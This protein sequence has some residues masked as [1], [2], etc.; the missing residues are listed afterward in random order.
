MKTI[1]EV[2]KLSTGYLAERSVERA[3]RLAE[4][5]LASCMGL[6]RLELYMQFDRPV[7]ESELERL[8]P[9][10]K[11]L[12]SH[13]P[14]EYVL[15]T[16]EFAGCTLTVNPNVL[17]PRPETEILVSLLIKRLEGVSLAGKALWDVCCGSGCIGLAL[18][19][20][21]PELRVTLS[22]VSTDALQLA[23][24]N[25]KANGLEV[26]LLQGDFLEPLEGRIVDILVCNPPYLSTSEYLNCPVSVRDFEPK[27]ALVGGEQ[28]TEFYER[29]AVERPPNV[30]LALEIGA[31]QGEA[32]QRIFEGQGKVVQDWSGK[33]RFF[34]LEPQS[35]SPV[36]CPPIC[37]VPS[38]KNSSS[39]FTD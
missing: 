30:L 31:T 39:S 11:R 29:L 7:V 12:G 16:L 2:L 17:I 25:A 36:E 35:F 26:E 6:K 8:R 10:L 27:L 37:L 33:D 18:K 23:E 1:G 20:R 3:R 5:V 19:K 28:G 21:F 15:G 4:E 24:Q 32:V 14:L 38:R 13:E 9:M 34:F 22:D